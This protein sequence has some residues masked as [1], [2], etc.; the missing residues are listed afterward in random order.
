MTDSENPVAAAG[1]ELVDAAQHLAEAATESVDEANEQA[2]AASAAA[3]AAV[4]APVEPVVEPVV[5]PLSAEIGAIRE[6]LNQPFYDPRVDGILEKLTAL[7]QE[8]GEAAAQA[9]QATL[10]TEQTAPAPVAEA[11]P[12]QEHAPTRVHPLLRKIGRG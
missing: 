9:V 11:A 8:A 1:D 3:I 7:P 12:V 5:D 6:R 10:E 2:A 4:A